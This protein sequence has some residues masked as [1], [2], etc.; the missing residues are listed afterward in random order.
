MERNL[1]KVR[2][3]RYKND[4]GAFY[5]VPNGGEA[6]RCKYPTRL[7]TYGRGCQHNC[8]YCYARSLLDFPELSVCEDVPSHYD[9]FTK[10]VNANSEDCCN[11]NVRRGNASKTKDRDDGYR[12]AY[13][14]RG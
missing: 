11:L 6:S 3:R 9:Y 10:N 7:D 13:P 12:D 4:Y 1:I 5:G 14:I 8:A 2:K